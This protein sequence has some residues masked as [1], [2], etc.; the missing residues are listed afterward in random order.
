M[1]RRKGAILVEALVGAS[2]LVVFISALALAHQTFLV[3]SSMSIEQTQASLLAE[4]GVEII[5]YLRDK[6]WGSHFVGAGANGP[7]SFAWDQEWTTT[8]PNVYI[9]EK[10]LRTY[11]SEIVKRNASFNIASVGTDD[12]NTRKVTVSVDWLRKGATTTRTMSTYITNIH[13]GE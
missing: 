12:P 4:E 2:I 1:N 3:R 13:Y 10:F 9:D 11:T 8:T 5:K 6:D 7:Y